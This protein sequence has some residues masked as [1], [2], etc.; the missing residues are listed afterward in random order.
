MSK[1]P[2]AGKYSCIWGVANGEAWLGCRVPEGWLYIY[3]VS[4]GF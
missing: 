4:Q 2:G 1:G 3:T